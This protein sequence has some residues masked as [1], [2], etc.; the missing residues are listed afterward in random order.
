MGL[1]RGVRLHGT[2]GDGVG[3]YNARSAPERLP[4]AALVIAGI[5]GTRQGTPRRM[6]DGGQ[7]VEPTIGSADDTQDVEIL[8]LD[9]GVALF[10]SMTAVCGEISPVP[11]HGCPESAGF[12]G[13]A[14]V[15]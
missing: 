9:A 15:N 11:R 12:D 14:G 3:E 7:R 10:P 8:G 1:G 4:G 2:V 6:A 13:R 5:E